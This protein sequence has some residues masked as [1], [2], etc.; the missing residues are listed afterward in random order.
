MR[1]VK[2]PKQ[3]HRSKQRMHLRLVVKGQPS[4]VVPGYTIERCEAR[5]AR[6]AIFWRE[7]IWKGEPDLDGGAGGLR[8]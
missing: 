6:Q 5:K 2:V 7:R 8:V 4:E 1:S 3:T